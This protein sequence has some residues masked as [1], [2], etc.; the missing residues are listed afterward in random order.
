MRSSYRNICWLAKA[1]EQENCHQFRCTCS[2]DIRSSFLLHLKWFSFIPL[3]RLF[4][5]YLIVTRTLKEA[6]DKE[7]LIFIHAAKKRV[8][9]QLLLFHFNKRNMSA[10]IDK[11]NIYWNYNLLWWSLS[12]IVDIFNIGKYI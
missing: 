1:I 9:V 6:Y 12:I 2:P 10:F 8:S 5:L 11:L 7:H 3:L 4:Y